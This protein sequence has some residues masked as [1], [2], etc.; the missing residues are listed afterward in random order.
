MPMPP[1]LTSLLPPVRGAGC[2]FVDEVESL[3]N[4]LL[5]LPL[6]TNLSVISLSI[7]RL[8]ENLYSAASIRNGLVSIWSH[9]SSDG[10]SFDR[11]CRS[12]S[13]QAQ[14]E[15][16]YRTFGLGFVAVLNRISTRLVL[17]TRGVPD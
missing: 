16:A 2:S 12:C 3:G 10:C 6:E 13:V 15:S 7:S 17:V 1:N 5:Q 11:M 9:E 4:C 14:G 8:T